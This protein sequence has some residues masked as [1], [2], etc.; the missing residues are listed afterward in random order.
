MAAAGVN[1]P[2]VLQ[3]RAAIRRRRAPR[4][5]RA[6]GRGRGRARGRRC[7]ALEGRATV[8]GAHAHGGGY[9]E[10]CADAGG[11]GAAAC[12]GAC[13]W[14]KPARIPETFFT[15]WTNVFDRGRLRPARPFWSMA[16][17]PASAPPPSSWRPPW[18]TVFATAGAPGQ[19]RRLREAGRQRAHQ[20][21]QGG[22]R[23]GRRGRD[24]RQG[25]RRDPRHGGRAT[26]SSESA[27]AGGRGAA[28]ADRF[29]QGP[30][31]AVQLHRADAQAPDLDRLDA[32][33][34][35]G[36]GEGRDRARLEAKVWPLLDAGK[37]KPSIYR[38][39]PLAR[40]RGAHGSWN[41]A[42]ISARSCSCAN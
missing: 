17:R 1:R 20:L 35:L 8:S 15:V 11:A 26:M 34:A 28:G 30:K 25:R 36:R 42:R 38:T 23:R 7:D 9:A 16:A 32:A 40:S 6:G 18:A 19:V 39:F 41:R 2:D 10:Y 22:L 14:W 3:R 31:V 29:S 27:G 5:A 37:V 4:P 24:R 21:S 13:R 33:A 12:P